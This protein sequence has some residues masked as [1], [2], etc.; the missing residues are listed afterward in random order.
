MTTALAYEAQQSL[1]ATVVFA[2]T[3]KVVTQ[4][5]NAKREK[6]DLALGGTGV[7]GRATVFGEDFFLLLLWHVYWHNEKAFK[8]HMDRVKQNLRPQRYKAIVTLSSY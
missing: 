2:V 6:C 5:L 8:D 7:G 3:L 4:L 1:T